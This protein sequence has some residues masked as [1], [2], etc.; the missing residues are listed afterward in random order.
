MFIPKTYK[1]DYKKKIEKARETDYSGKE[2]KEQFSDTVLTLIP[3][4]NSKDY[5]DVETSGQNKGTLKAK[6]AIIN[7]DVTIK[8]LLT[9][10]N[11]KYVKID[12]LP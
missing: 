2:Y 6:S 11:L 4:S 10:F 8:N 12:N 5:F 3:N 1:D 9:I 7:A